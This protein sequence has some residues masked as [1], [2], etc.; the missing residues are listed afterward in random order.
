[1][2]RAELEKAGIYYFKLNVDFKTKIPRHYIGMS[3]RSVGECMRTH[4]N[5]KNKKPIDK[6][7]AKYPPEDYK[8][9][10]TFRAVMLDEI[11][12]NKIKELKAIKDDKNAVLLV[13]EKTGIMKMKSLYPKGYNMRLDMSHSMTY[14]DY[15]F[16]F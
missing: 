5:E 2:R 10:W 8:R 13:L 3:S 14:V 16:T 4:I 12:V 9:E 6:L 11:P 1:M 7:L 15:L